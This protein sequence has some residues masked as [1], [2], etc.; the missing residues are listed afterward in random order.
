MAET[1]LT[2]QLHCCLR[3]EHVAKRIEGISLGVL[4]SARITSDST[5]SC[6][7][8]HQDNFLLWADKYLGMR[9]ATQ[10]YTWWNWTRKIW[11]NSYRSV[12]GDFLKGMDS[13][14][15]IQVSDLD[16]FSI[17]RKIFSTVYVQRNYDIYVVVDEEGKQKKKRGNKK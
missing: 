8:F 7:S 13:L 15:R 4:W 2:K 16:M 11:P 6:R 17:F 1:E 3:F 12:L 14:M 5:I 9:Y 10:R